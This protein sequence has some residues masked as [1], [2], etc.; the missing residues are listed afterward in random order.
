MGVT[1]LTTKHIELDALLLPLL[2]LNI[3]VGRIQGY[4]MECNAAITL[5]LSSA[6]TIISL[7]SVVFAVFSWLEAHRPIV[8]ARVI[9]VESSGTFTALQLLIENTGNRPARGIVIRCDIC[10]LQLALNPLLVSSPPEDVTRLFS[11]DVSIPVLENDREVTCAFGHFAADNSSTWIPGSRLP[12]TIKYK[13]LGRRNFN[14]KIDLLLADD[15]S[16]TG[17]QWGKG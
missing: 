8:I 11:S 3:H 5:V 1:V 15:H 12:I 17:L 4:K 9:T 6:A 16:F 7:L 14:Q 13:G 2:P 10:A